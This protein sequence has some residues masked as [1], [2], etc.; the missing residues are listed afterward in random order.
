MPL[1]KLKFQKKT[2]LS[3]NKIGLLIF[4]KILEMSPYKYLKYIN[5]NTNKYN[6]NCSYES[7]LIYAE[8][9]NKNGNLTYEYPIKE[10]VDFFCQHSLDSKKNKLSKRWINK[11][12]HF[13]KHIFKNLITYQEEFL[14]TGEEI[15]FKPLTLQEFL[16]N[17]PYP[18][19]DC[20]RLSRLSKNI[21]I[22]TP[23]NKYITLNELLVSK[24]TCNAFQVKNIILR[25]KRNLNDIEI[26]QIL[27]QKK[28][29]KFSVRSICNY[30]KLL[31]IPSYKYRKKYFYGNDI[32][33]SQ[34]IPIYSKNLKEIP[35]TSGVYEIRINDKVKYKI[36]KS[37]V[38]YL[39]AS[40]NLRKRLSCYSGTSMKNNCLKFFSGNNILLVRYFTCNK[41][42]KIEKELLSSFKINYGEL[43]K[44]N[45][46]GG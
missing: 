43:P 32:T 14:L 3:S 18:Q 22:K 39:G 36:N 28:G 16:K 27:K 1:P 9:F 38:I 26:Q 40:K 4:A 10:F 15:N 20:S 44:A 8:T 33:F 23:Q 12:N 31:K 25:S 24:K 11:R 2:P 17:F 13:T 7:N 35:P 46:L 19:L 42:F 41:P 29:L 30:R 37:E 34:P 21:T 45:I 5:E 6:S